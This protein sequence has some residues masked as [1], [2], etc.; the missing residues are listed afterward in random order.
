M[1]R[2]HKPVQLWETPKILQALHLLYSEEVR[3]SGTGVC[4][5]LHMDEIV[6]NGAHAMVDIERLKTVIIQ[7]AE[8]EL[9]P[10]FSSGERGEKLDGSVITEADMAMQSRLRADLAAQWPD[11]PLLGEEMDEAS[12]Q[13]M[14]QNNATA[15]WCVDPLDGTSNFAAG[16]PFFSV[17]VALLDKGLPVVGVVYDPVR[18]ECFWAMPGKGA[19]CNDTRLSA[20]GLDLSLSQAVALVDFKRLDAALA[21]RLAEQPPYSSQRSF[22][23]VALDW[24]WIA[25]GRGHVYLHGKQRIWDYAA[26]S[27]ILA[28]AGGHAATLAG[29]AVYHADIAPR[30]AVAALDEGMFQAWCAWLAMPQGIA[31]TLP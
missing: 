7:A 21:R 28:E 25:A 20:R 24:C 3:V 4:A 5:V 9:L 18:R 31:D 15:L 14:L 17:S 19:W 26:G 27:L 13:R 2:K 6:I 29:E 22:G 8:Q 23:S 11:F 16:V 1:A 10:R 30:S 12:Q